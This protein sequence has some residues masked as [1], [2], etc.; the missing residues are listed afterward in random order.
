LRFLSLPDGKKKESVVNIYDDG[1][2]G[3]LLTL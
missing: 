3:Y 2:N 1:N